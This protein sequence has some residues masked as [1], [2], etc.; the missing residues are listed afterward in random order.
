MTVTRA[1]APDVRERARRFAHA[2]RT[3]ADR[4]ADERAYVGGVFRCFGADV[5]RPKLTGFGP[6]PERG[7]IVTSGGPKSGAAQS[8][9]TVG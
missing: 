8:W 5:Q 6:R 2:P 3:Q 4:A 1:F 7:V 9:A